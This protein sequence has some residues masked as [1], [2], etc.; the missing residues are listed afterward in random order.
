MIGARSTDNK[1]DDES[2]PASVR[3]DNQG[4]VTHAAQ[5]LS[6]LLMLDANLQCAARRV[7]G[8]MTMKSFTATLQRHLIRHARRSVLLVL[9]CAILSGIVVRANDPARLQVALHGHTKSI[10]ALTF[11]PDGATLATSS[12]DGTVRLWRVRDGAAQVVLH[13]RAGRHTSPEVFWSPDGRKLATYSRRSFEDFGETQ[14]WDAD[15]GHLRAALE[16]HRGNVINVEWSPDSRMLL[17]TCDDGA[18]RV[19]DAATG[20]LRATL[21]QNEL[22]QKLT[23]SLFKALFTTKNLDFSF[24]FGTF[25]ADGRAVVTYS[26][27]QP[28]K[29]W[30]AATGALHATLQMDVTALQPKP[31]F[32]LLFSPDKHFIV[33]KTPDS[34]ELLDAA[35]GDSARTLRGVGTAV[36]FNPAG[37]MLLAYIT[38]PFTISL[39]DTTTGQK[40]WDVEHTPAGLGGF[41]WSPDGARIVAMGYGSNAR[42]LDAHTG[43]ILTKLPYG[44][45]TNDWLCGD[46]DCEPFVF[47]AD[48]RVFLKQ[49]QVVKLWRAADGTLL[50]LLTEARGPGVFSPTEPRLLATRSRDKKSVLLWTIEPQ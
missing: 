16:G 33:R 3:C 9:I 18:A 36:S 12:A 13:V 8:L 42:L 20:S 41:F 43:R 45:C 30:D 26:I 32:N 28:P 38:S 29:I 22:R 2:G 24:T 34:V 40:L 50:A 21:A 10:G 7:E 31:V 5:R 25:A 4:S 11:S 6:A 27:E 39:W 17:T 48:G 46:N 37:R 19:W 44:G 35:T 23:N 49:K 1:A 15:T 47:S 14:I